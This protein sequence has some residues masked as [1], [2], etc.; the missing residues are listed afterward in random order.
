MLICQPASQPGRLLVELPRPLPGAPFRQPQWGRL[1]GAGLDDVGADLEVGAMDLL[2]E[3]R[4]VQDQPV[5]P[6]LERGSP[7]CSGVGSSACRLVPM[8]PS[9]TRTRRFSASRYGDSFI[10]GSFSLG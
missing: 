5:H 4:A 7:N 2:D 10:G 8:A 9:N 3:L 1:E 6:P